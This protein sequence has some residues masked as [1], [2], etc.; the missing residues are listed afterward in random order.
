MIVKAIEITKKYT[1]DEH[2]SI[3]ITY[4]KIII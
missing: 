4:S 3:G 2:N 1:P